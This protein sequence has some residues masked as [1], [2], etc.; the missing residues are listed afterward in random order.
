MSPI[1]N[2]LGQQSHHPVKTVQEQLLREL[3]SVWPVCSINE[4]FPELVSCLPETPEA[5]DSTLTQSEVYWIKPTDTYIFDQSENEQKDCESM[6]D[7]QSYQDS[8]NFFSP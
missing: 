1:R 7:Q 2:F 3:K 6:D 8:E 5:C 4:D